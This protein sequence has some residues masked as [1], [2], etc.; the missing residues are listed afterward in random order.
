AA[1]GLSLAFP[2]VRVGRAAGTPLRHVVLLMRE[3]R[4]F[5][6]CFTG[7]PGADGVPYSAPTRQATDYCL[8]DPPH[9]ES[10]F[11]AMAAAGATAPAALVSFTEAQ[12]PLGWALARRF[13]LCDRYFA[14]VL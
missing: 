13:T 3:N 6:R 12:L 1:L 9:T 4:S 7:F 2:S 11:R 10:A 14:S 8:A 5:T